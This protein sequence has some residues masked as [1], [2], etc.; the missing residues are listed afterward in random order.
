VRR[1]FPHVREEFPHVREEFP[2]A[3]QEFPHVRQENPTRPF[4]RKI[5][6]F[7]QKRPVPP[8]FHMR[9][10]NWDSADPEMYFG[11]PNLHWGGG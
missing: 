4:S 2:H 1:E 3:R 5:A 8:L 7:A 10:A 9:T 11:N 6:R